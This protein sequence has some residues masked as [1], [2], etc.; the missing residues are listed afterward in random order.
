M[1]TLLSNA[2]DH[3]LYLTFLVR[4]RNEEL[5]DRLSPTLPVNVLVL[6]A[7]A[8]RV[9]SMLSSFQW[10]DNTGKLY[11]KAYATFG[12]TRTKDTAKC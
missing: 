11:F 8:E 7:G 5:D 4:W 1:Y 6:G 9:A 12:A 2:E 10:R 3:Q